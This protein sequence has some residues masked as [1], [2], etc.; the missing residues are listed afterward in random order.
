MAE[1]TSAVNSADLDC[2]H[3]V[4]EVI[5]IFMPTSMIMKRGDLQM[6]TALQRRVA[7]KGKQVSGGDVIAKV[8]GQ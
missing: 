3:L 2:S 6:T 7:I 1:D 5:Y 4:R 8:L